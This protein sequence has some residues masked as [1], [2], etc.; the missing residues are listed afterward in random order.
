MKTFDLTGQAIAITGASSGFGHHFAGLLAHAGAK[1]LLGARREEKLAQRVQD[2]EA[3][4]GVALAKPLDVTKKDSIERFLEAGFAA[5]GKIDVLINNAGVES[6]AKTP[7]RSGKDH[8]PAVVI[9][10]YRVKRCVEGFDE[11]QRQCIQLVGSIECQPSH[12]L[13]W[14]VDKNS[15]T[16]SCHTPALD[17]PHGS[18]QTSL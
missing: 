10:I 6:G 14:R 7:S 1:V 16:G 18:H 15:I 5:F 2:I 11:L 13:S 8:H 4:G 17:Q 12:A 3:A 9:G